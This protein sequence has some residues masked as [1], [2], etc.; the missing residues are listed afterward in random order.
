[1]EVKVGGD[2]DERRQPTTLFGFSDLADPKLG[3]SVT[4]NR[5]WPGVGLFGVEAHNFGDLIG[6]RDADPID[7]RPGLYTFVKGTFFPGDTVQL[8]LDRKGRVSVFHNRTYKYTFQTP[9]MRKQVYFHVY[10]QGGDAVKNTHRISVREIKR[11]A[12][13]FLIFPKLAVTARPIPLISTT[14]GKA[15]SSDGLAKKSW[16]KK[17]FPNT[18][19]ALTVGHT[20][21][22]FDVCVSPDNQY[23]I[24]ASRDNMLKFW[25]CTTA[26]CDAC[27]VSGDQDLDPVGEGYQRPT[28]FNSVTSWND[29]LLV[30]RAS[31]VAAG[32]GDSSI[33]LWIVLPP[34]AIEHNEISGRIF[35]VGRTVHAADKADKGFGVSSLEWDARTR[36]LYACGGKL[37][38]AYNVDVDQDSEHYGRNFALVEAKITA[39]KFGKDKVGHDVLNGKYKITPIW[40]ARFEGRQLSL[41]LDSKCLGVCSESQKKIVILSTKDGSTLRSLSHNVGVTSITLTLNEVVFGDTQGKVIMYD[42]WKDWPE[43]ESELVPALAQTFEGHAPVSIWQ[44]SVLS[45]PGKHDLERFVLASCGSGMVKVWKIGEG[46]E[47][48]HGSS[49][50]LIKNNLILT[51]VAHHAAV[52]AMCVVGND[53]AK[54]QD[55]IMT[56]YQDTPAFASLYTGS[57]DGKARRWDITDKLDQ[58]VDHVLA[59]PQQQYQ[60]PALSV[61]VKVPLSWFIT[62]AQLALAVV[63][64]T[65]DDLK[66]TV[67]PSAEAVEKF[68]LKYIVYSVVAWT[69]IVIMAC[70][71]PVRLREKIN[72]I[73]SAADYGVNV[74]AQKL[75][76]KKEHLLHKVEF[77]PYM[78]SLFGL[79]TIY[80][81]LLPMNDCAYARENLKM[82]F[83]GPD[84]LVLEADPGLVCY[85]GVHSLL[86]VHNMVLLVLFLGFT[87]PVYVVL[88]DCDR[89]AH[90]ISWGTCRR[91]FE[92]L[93]PFNWWRCA[94]QYWPGFAGQS[95]QRRRSY[96]F[97]TAFLFYQIG[98]TS[99]DILTT[100]KP[101]VRFGVEFMFALAMLIVS[102]WSP[103]VQHPYF[104]AG[105]RVAV[106]FLFVYPLFFYMVGME[107]KLDMLQ[108]E[109]DH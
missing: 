95:S 21:W 15:D 20:N 9:M 51:I 64:T 26:N 53:L 102:I 3:D 76:L 17:C 6:W 58:G 13:S 70:D 33:D 34:F 68:Y 44:T 59:T 32:R 45:R 36:T 62:M 89:L 73:M 91:V 56:V 2:E 39:Q 96:H 105:L 14:Y 94:S 63:A 104:L 69:M 18:T 19:K 86:F 108:H 4:F 72:H 25:H 24:S 8:L 60:N 50:N 92:R 29:E 31:V 71:L 22:I 82:K 101:S 84:Y 61:I 43:S 67:R 35:H 98:L 5:K 103:P 48:E 81:G 46:R 109:L 55:D 83:T 85:T 97:Q 65:V 107:K 12:D 66:E 38:I 10:I 7:R 90:N 75:K 100:F 42:T 52:S 40:K 79:L 78:V 80:K 37:V 28:S 47:C 54:L 87:A 77:I 30:C 99:V 49:K 23:C 57:F 88:G 106:L 27:V 11:E 41:A 74:Q 16:F 1:M 93:N